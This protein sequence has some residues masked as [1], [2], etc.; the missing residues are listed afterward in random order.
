[1]ITSMTG[2]AALTREDDAATVSV[3]VRAVNHRFLDVQVR[4]P[5]SLADREA[6]LRA[7]VQQAIARGRV[8]LGVSVQLRQ[9]AVPTV[10]LNEPFV[11]AL[12]TA[13][14]HARLRGVVAGHLTPG[15]LL[16]LPHAITIRDQPAVSP[17][18]AGDGVGALVDLA[19]EA[20]LAEL[21]RMR[22]HEGDQLRR[23][24]DSRREGLGVLITRIAEAAAS[25]QQALE[26]RLAARVAELTG[27]LPLDRVAV[28]Q[29]IVRLVARSDIS[30][31][32][33]RFRAHLVHWASLSDAPEACG[34]K[35]DFL[36]QEMNREINTIGSK[37][38]GAGVSELI[39]SAKAE[40]ERMREQV[41]NVE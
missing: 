15:D 33:T 9:A 26:A 32:I 4:L 17:E 24:L 18:Q 23:D 16:R 2:F 30:E 40:L 37:A 8:E 28:A 3:T 11:V 10:E 31:E 25:G 39:V 5:Q 22:V 29:E 27:D 41:Q 34:R 14:E 21:G 38:D 1:M 12:E 36:L 35:L 6:R 20:A 7:L 19:V 13:L